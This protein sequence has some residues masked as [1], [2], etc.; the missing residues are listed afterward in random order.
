[1]DRRKFLAG[2]AAPAVLLRRRLAAEPVHFSGERRAG[3][4][5]G[6]RFFKGAADGAEH[7]EFDDARWSDVRL[8]HDWAIENPFDLTPLLRFGE[9]NVLAVRLMPEDHS[10]RWYPGAGIYRNVWLTTTGP[11]H[12]E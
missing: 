11:R 3:F 5:D 9:Q 12:V 10:S 8:P 4:N 6:W 1:M 2:L 7:L